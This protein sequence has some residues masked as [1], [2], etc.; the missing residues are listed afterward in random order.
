MM[1]NGGVVRGWTILPLV[2][3]MSAALGSPVIQTGPILHQR[4]TVAVAQEP[5]T[6]E[7]IIELIE[8]EVQSADILYRQEGQTAY[9]EAPMSTIDGTLFFGTIPAGD[10]I[11]GNLE[12][13]LAFV[14]SDGRM[15]AFPDFEPTLNPVVVPVIA[16]QGQE[17]DAAAEL[18]AGDVS[19]A[20]SDILI[21]AP[22]P[23]AVYLAENVVVA[24]SLF[25]VPNVD[26]SSIRLFLDG[27]D[28]TGQAEISADIVTFNPLALRTGPHRIEFRVANLG[29]VL[30][31][32]VTWQFRV[33][34]RATATSALAFRQSGRITIGTKEDN[35]EG[36]VLNVQTTRISY[37]AGWNWLKLQSNI[38]FSSDEDPF[39]PARNRLT[40]KIVT[41]I[42]SIGIGDVTPRL[43]RFALDG[44]R[45]RGFE[46]DLNL[47]LIRLRFAQGELERATQG[48]DDRAYKVTDYLQTGAGPTAAFGLGLTRTNYG[49]R[50]DVT[51][52]RASL[53]S[54]QRFELAL[55]FLKAKDNIASVDSLIG[56]GQIVLT[57]PDFINRLFPNETADT[58]STTFEEIQSKAAAAGDFSYMLPGDDWDGSSPKDNIVLGG[59]LSLAL[60]NRRIVLQS[61]FAFSML[62]TNI[63]DPVFRFDELDTLSI[64]GDTT[65]DGS[66]GGLIDI[67]F[68]PADF[69]DIF[70]LNLNM[71][72]LI[73]IDPNLLDPDSP[74][75]DPLQAI[76]KMPSMAYHAS[77]KFNYLG[78]FITAEFQQ[79]GPEFNSLGNP[80]LQR[81]VRIRTLS[82]R[83]RM[84]GNRLFVTALYRSTDD[85]I[86]KLPEDNITTTET[87]SI[88][89]SLNLGI[90]LPS[91]NIGSRTVTRNNGRTTLD[92]LISLDTAG[93]NVI[94]GFRD[95][96]ENTST[97]TTSLG[98]T[99]RLQALG[100]S[101]NL[102]LTLN[103]TAITD[104]FADDRGL[105][106]T[107]RSPVATSDIVA[108]SLLSIFSQALNTSIT[109]STNAS[110]FGEGP[111]IVITNA[112]GDTTATVP[113][114]IAQ[115]LLN[116]GLSATLRLANSRLLIRGGIDFINGDTS[117]SLSIF[118]PPSF[119]RIGIK[120]GIEY[121]LIQNLR[122]VASFERRSR[123]LDD[124][125]I[126]PRL[127]SVLA[128]SLNY[129]F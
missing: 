53:G 119:T 114:M 69:E 73:P 40:V 124:P 126:E 33:T 128:A 46:V 122:L 14:L 37:R 57:D 93:V 76:L 10:I 101:H 39:K 77:A 32:P 11:S 9:Q 48:R 103:N 120:G 29:G 16:G 100:S 111:D 110:Q 105:D 49:F 98:L 8:A 115:D 31:Q 84:F 23:D 94:A 55:T 102:N 109:F 70:I 81:N 64:L 83:I 42:L 74:D 54:G 82:D 65:L 51:A 38:K 28:V 117:R 47:K 78:N 5:L 85:D 123:T 26:V 7:A 99:Y 12:Y 96:R 68:D 15:V 22:E 63:W 45:I 88:S 59:D 90:G 20:P 67:P 97:T 56:N 50:R 41:P 61:G 75:F 6:L 91:L 60:D 121:K 3:L 36:G 4:P 1:Q 92:T 104:G 125:D 112:D 35:I 127:S 43:N 71:V 17:A 19:T 89:G 129:I 113:G 44:K 21:M 52:I 108:V 66:M 107:F 106:P 2:G 24:I 118:A 30:L 58:V 95:L 79:V 62:N 18:A 13:Y 86:I 87:I 116:V 27:R 34:R 72:P 25:N 80:N